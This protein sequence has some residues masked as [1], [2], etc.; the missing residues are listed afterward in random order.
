MQLFNSDEAVLYISKNC[1]A[2]IKTHNPAHFH[3]KHLTGAPVWWEIVVS[4]HALGEQD[5]T[6]RG[7][8]DF[9]EISL[10]SFRRG[11]AVM[12][13]SLLTVISPDISITSY[14][15]QSA[16]G[17][18]CVYTVRRLSLSPASG[19]WWSQIASPLVHTTQCRERQSAGVT[20]CCKG[21]VRRETDEEN[22]GFC[23]NL[24]RV[25]WETK[26]P[27]LKIT[28]DNL[29][30]FSLQCPHGQF[31][32]ACHTPSPLADAPFLKPHVPRA[33]VTSHA[34][35]RLCCPLPAAPVQSVS[36][37]RALRE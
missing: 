33:K 37:P 6:D 19:R 12:N 30:S 31:T 1:G 3:L 7:A 26:C 29:H 15:M 36:S 4:Y 21:G 17:C 14:N 25:R 23:S 32:N 10:S 27:F 22:L 35:D 28:G 20:G 9:K 24:D 5:E 13:G 2:Q 11:M 8:S 34:A 16:C 18:A